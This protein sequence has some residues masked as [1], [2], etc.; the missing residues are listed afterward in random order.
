MFW[1][2]GDGLLKDIVLDKMSVL[3]LNFVYWGGQPSDKMPD[4]FN[5]TDVLV[6]PSR[7]EGMPLVVLEAIAC[8]ANVVAT[9]VGGI[10][11]AIGSEFCVGL[12]CLVP[13]MAQRVSDLLYNPV[14]QYIPSGFS[15]EETAKKEYDI[16][17]SLLNV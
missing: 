4:I 16:Y 6:L 14:P 8:G 12:E 7:N 17:K 3:G 2:V 5:C 9:D 15:W 1:I 13:N 10:A 11:E